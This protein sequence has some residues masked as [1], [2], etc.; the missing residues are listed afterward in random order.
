MSFPAVVVSWGTT[1]TGHR[2]LTRSLLPPHR[3]SRIITHSTPVWC[4]DGPNANVKIDHLSVLR[5]KKKKKKAKSAKAEKEKEE[6]EEKEEKEE[7]EERGGNNAPGDNPNDTE[8]LEVYNPETETHADSLNY[9]DDFAN[10]HPLMSS[11]N[12]LEMSRGSNALEQSGMSVSFRDHPVSALEESY[13][14]APVGK[15]RGGKLPPRPV[16]AS[17]KAFNIYSTMPNRKSATGE[18]IRPSTAGSS[19]GLTKSMFFND[20]RPTSAVTAPNAPSKTAELFFGDD[21]VSKKKGADKRRKSMVVGS[22]TGLSRL[23]EFEK[24]ANDNKKIVKNMDDVVAYYN[25]DA[26]E[27]DR[28]EQ[29]GR[30]RRNRKFPPKTPPNHAVTLQGMREMGDFARTNSAQ[31]EEW[32]KKMEIR[33]KA[34]KLQSIGRGTDAAEM[35]RKAQ[36]KKDQKRAKVQA[37]KDYLETKRKEREDEERE[38]VQIERKEHDMTSTARTEM[39]AR[40]GLAHAAGIFTRVIAVNEQARQQAAR[41]LTLMAQVATKELLKHLKDAKVKSERKGSVKIETEGIKRVRRTLVQEHHDQVYKSLIHGETKKPEKKAMRNRRIDSSDFLENA[42]KVIGQTDN[43][44]EGEMEGEEE[45]KKGRSFKRGE[46]VAGGEHA[47]QQPKLMEGEIMKVR[48]VT[49]G[50]VEVAGQLKFFECTLNV[51]VVSEEEIEVRCELGG[52][53][54]DER[55]C[56]LVQK[57]PKL[58]IVERESAVEYARNLVDRLHLVKMKRRII[59]QGVE[60]V[61]GWEKWSL[62]KDTANLL[63]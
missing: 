45:G 23:R 19:G 22:I 14:T 27:E 37:K 31:I 26:W 3:M 28:R 38:K 56:I 15:R 1:E 11:F 52:M 16:S 46:V 40:K 53:E 8:M 41:D 49:E 33:L 43:D 2:G 34:E 36:K 58:I 50:E 32:E 63:I 39:A 12:N 9:S 54:G 10:Q 48:S 55:V 30:M 44:S 29:I 7:K 47:Y 24:I 20:L 57:V 21:V 18:V 61:D 25:K 60:R 13:N 5:P 51:E 59:V 17:S 6:R 62:V 42:L 35:K 4:D